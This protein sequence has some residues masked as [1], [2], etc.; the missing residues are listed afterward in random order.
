M[1]SE[2]DNPEGQTPEDPFSEAHDVEGTMVVTTDEEIT[3]Q[4]L[5]ETIKDSTRPPPTGTEQLLANELAIGILSPPLEKIRHICEAA[6]TIKPDELK[7]YQMEEHIQEVIKVH[8]LCLALSSHHQ[9]IE[10]DSFNNEMPMVKVALPFNETEAGNYLL[11]WTT[12]LHFESYVIEGSQAEKSL[13]RVRQKFIELFRKRELNK[14]DRNTLLQ[15]KAT[16]MFWL[17]R[18]GFKVENYRMVESAFIKWAMPQ[19]TQ[20]LNNIMARIS[21]E[22]FKEALGT[23]MGGGSLSQSRIRSTRTRPR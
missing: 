17:L 1:S 20:W 22:S 15:I 16:F 2:P 12:E 23:L 11:P 7:D 13:L 5:L 4:G 19:A 8:T 18:D 6:M 10:W 14:L 3:V 21:P 9:T